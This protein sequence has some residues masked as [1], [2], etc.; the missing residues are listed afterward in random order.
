MLNGLLVHIFNS[1]TLVR[2]CLI[3]EP[4]LL[5]VTDYSLL[6]ILNVLMFLDVEKN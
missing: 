6:H 2:L 4:I 5:S 3:Y 1:W